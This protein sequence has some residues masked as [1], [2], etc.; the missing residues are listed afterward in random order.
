MG[1]PERIDEI[2]SLIKEIWMQH[3][4]TRFNELI[5]HLQW[6]YSECNKEVVSYNMYE[7]DERHGVFTFSPVADID[8]FYVEDDNFL[9]YLRR[10]VKCKRD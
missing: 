1:N 9:E 7:K 8:L 6:D 10:K 2:L 3:P 5:E 4:D